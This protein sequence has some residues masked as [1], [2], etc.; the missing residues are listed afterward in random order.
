MKTNRLKFEQQERFVKEYSRLFR[1]NSKK[2]KKKNRK[3]FQLNKLRRH[4]DKRKKIFIIQ[5]F[6]LLDLLNNLNSD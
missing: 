2:F 4:L 3:V 1:E 6:D 5:D